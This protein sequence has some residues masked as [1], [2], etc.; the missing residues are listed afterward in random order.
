MMNPNRCRHWGKLSNNTLTARYTNIQTNIIY[1]YSIISCLFKSQIICKLYLISKMFTQNLNYYKSPPQHRTKNNG[2]EKQWPTIGR[3]CTPVREAFSYGIR[4]ISLWFNEVWPYT[5]LNH[6]EICRIP[7]EN[8]SRTGVRILP[9]IA[10]LLHPQVLSILWSS[11]NC[12]ELW[13]FTL[14]TNKVIPLTRAH[15][16]QHEHTTHMTRTASAAFILHSATHTLSFINSRCKQ[17]RQSSD[18]YTV[19]GNFWC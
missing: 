3:M 4:H 1:L 15:R 8:V 18:D 12:R 9:I 16:Y 17:A 14:S 6:N 19:T 10:C 13:G 11:L 2:H 7:Y 5:S